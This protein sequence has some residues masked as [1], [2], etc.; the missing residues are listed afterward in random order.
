VR[1]S[2]IGAG[3]EAQFLANHGED[4]RLEF[5]EHRVLERLR[6]RCHDPFVPCRRCHEP[7]VPL[8]CC[9]EPFVP[10]SCRCEPFVPCSCRCEPF[11]PCP[12]YCEPFEPLCCCVPFCGTGCCEP[13]ISAI[14]LARAKQG[15]LT[16]M[17]TFD[18]QIVH[19]RRVAGG[20][21]VGG[22][23]DVIV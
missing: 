4:R 19:G 21:Y 12:C 15:L 2:P 18:W 9:C 11:V 6:H 1:I 8:F 23:L 22:F 5:I 17:Q 16:R 13:P 3:M 20:D 10:C 14:L 7:F